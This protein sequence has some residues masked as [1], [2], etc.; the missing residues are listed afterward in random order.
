MAT[1]RC[2]E[3]ESRNLRSF[4]LCHRAESGT[5][6]PSSWRVCP[7]GQ[8]LVCARAHGL[9]TLESISEGRFLRLAD[10]LLSLVL[11]LCIRADRSLHQF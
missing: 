1:L 9:P 7:R 3:N 5:G 10:L 4:G 6:G 2:R 8:R 11:R